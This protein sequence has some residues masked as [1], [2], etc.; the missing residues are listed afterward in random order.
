VE[1][2]KRVEDVDWGWSIQHINSLVNQKLNQIEA[3]P[4]L[5]PAEKRKR[6]SNVEKA[7]QRILRG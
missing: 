2:N 7:W 3:D 5:K 1:A 4:A 6:V